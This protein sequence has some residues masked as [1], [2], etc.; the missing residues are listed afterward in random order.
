MSL[1]LATA[2]D[3]AAAHTMA[4]PQQPPMIDVNGGAAGALL[5]GLIL[6]TILIVRWKDK[7]YG[8]GEKRA[9]LFTAVACI[10]LAGSAG[11]I[12]ADIFGS[13]QDVGNT[14]GTSVQNVSTG[15]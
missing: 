11:G 8:E 6:C 1:R 2:I 5:I 12:I 13:V 15:R 14:I 9:I 4:A 3:T 10:L 7:K